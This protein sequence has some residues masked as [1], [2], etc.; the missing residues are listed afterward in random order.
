MIPDVVVV[1]FE[2]DRIE[3]RPDYPPKPVGVALKLPGEAGQYLAWGHP[4]KNNCTF[5]DA[6]ELLTKVWYSKFE[7]LFHNAKFDCAVAAEKL[8]LP[9]PSWER[10]HDTMF[11]DYLFDPHAKSG[12]LK[13]RAEE[14]LD[15]PP[16]ERDEV[17]DWIWQHRKELVA[18]YGGKITRAKKGP[19]SAGA[20]LSKAPGSVVAPYAA[21]DVERTYGL[22]KPLYRTIAE[23]GML[24]AYVRE[25]Q[26]L[27]ILAENERVGMRVDVAQLGHDIPMYEEHMEYAEEWLRKRL[28]APGLSF[29]DD[30]AVAQTFLE[31]G[32]IREE[33]F[34]L[35][36]SGQMSVSKDN[37]HPKLYQDQEV[38][39]AY[40]YR[41]R[42]ETCLKMFMKP[43]YEQAM[44][45]G[46]ERVST[47]WNQIRSDGGGTRTGRPSTNKPNFLNISKD[48]EGRPDGYEH[49]EHLEIN[50]LPLVRR[51]V[52]PDE[53]HKFI[54]LDFAGQE[55]RVFAHFESGDLW[56]AYQDDPS[57]DVHQMVADR[58]KEISPDTELDR[59]KTKIINFRTIYGSG[60]RGLASSLMC[61]YQTAK[62]FKAMHAKALPGMKLVNEEILR[63]IRRGDPIRTWGGRAYFCEEPKW[64]DKYN[65]M[66]SFEYKL[67]NYLVQGSA[68]DLT[69]QAII[70]WYYSSERD[71]RSRFLVTVYDEIAISAP[72]EV[73][74]RE[75]QVLKNVMEADRLTVPM[76]ADGAEGDN[77]HEAK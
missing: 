71:E 42:M 65:R 35:T 16:E 39:R 8:D 19:H 30:V 27:P 25:R 61:D 12:G 73:S 31:R 38:A 70:D 1:D 74:A 49:P 69:K 40:G 66:M 68:A 5:N 32:V 57:I 36:K 43:W 23:M 34:T 6:M 59:T 18:R 11:L 20:W 51:Y 3:P 72:S 75:L 60:V 24:P 7:L 37:L 62:Q 56:Q 26:I 9:W 17:A 41:N 55:L 50:K 13:E 48:F 53:G 45:R 4:E 44:L 52:L 28:R 67:L 14:L 63:I 15:W 21:G 58:I 22:F 54:D 2:T 77:W 47:N 10:I 33:D 29:N 46:D 76:L 64:S